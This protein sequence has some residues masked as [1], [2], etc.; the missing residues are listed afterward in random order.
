M[1]YKVLKLEPEDIE[2]PLGTEDM[3]PCFQAGCGSYLRKIKVDPY[4]AY[5]PDFKLVSELA[6]SCWKRYP[7]TG[8]KLLIAC[9][10]YE[11][12]SRINGLTYEDYVYKDDEGKETEVL[13]KLKDGSEK[14]VYQQGNT[15]FLSGKRIPIQ[16]GM[17]RYLVPHEYGHAVFNYSARKLGYDSSDHDALEKVYAQI[18]GI[19]N[20]P[21]KYS[22]GSWHRSI[23]EV[24]ANDFRVLFMQSEKEFWPH[25]VPLPK[26]NSP[27]GKW[28]KQT[29]KICLK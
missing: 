24:I 18:R 17:L 29:E 6:A 15:I 11:P 22:G 16:P 28:W 12:L 5:A 10:P 23:C 2:W 14:K 4:P 3:A 1:D 20:V 7:L 27:I 9:L 21:K 26:W 13:L 19:E 25:E 8:T